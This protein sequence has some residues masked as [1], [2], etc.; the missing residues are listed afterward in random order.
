MSKKGGYGFLSEN[1]TLARRCAA[2]HDRHVT[3]SD[4]ARPAAVA[5][6]RAKQQRTARENIADLCD[7]GTFVEY[8]PLVL[9][10]QRQRRS[11]AELIERSP[12]D[13]M[14][15][16]VGAVNGNVFG[17]PASRC[18]I[19]SY[20]YTVFAGTQGQQNHRKTDRMI[21]VAEQGRM[22]LVLFAEGG[23]LGYSHPKTL[24]PWSCKFPMALWISPCKTK[25]R[26]WP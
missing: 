13:G 2:E 23:G 15:T 16:G 6:R 14:V 18:V 9:A 25:P 8:G 7:P 11:V 12:A 20:D 22:P 21:D 1:A 17:D 10:A 5:R 4:A 26:P 3:T 19:M 24:A